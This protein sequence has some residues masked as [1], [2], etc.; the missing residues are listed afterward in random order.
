VT[1]FIRLEGAGSLECFLPKAH[2]FLTMLKMCFAERIRSA[3]RSLNNAKPFGEL[4]PQQTQGRVCEPEPGWPRHRSIVN[5][6]DIG[7]S[8]WRG[9]E[10]RLL[11]CRAHSSGSRKF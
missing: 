8:L 11:R 9:V 2:P 6:N 3:R 5:H 7:R 10:R 4:F 1:T